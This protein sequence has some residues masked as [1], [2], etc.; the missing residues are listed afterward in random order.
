VAARKKTVGVGVAMVVVVRVAVGAVVGAM[1]R[2]AVTMAEVTMAGVTMA[3]VT[4]AGVTMAG[5]MKAAVVAIGVRERWMAVAVMLRREGQ[6]ERTLVV[7]EMG[8]EEVE[9]RLWVKET[10]LKVQG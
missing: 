2:I 7:M 1:L 5:V 3:G 8:L 6:E 4:M 9:R 10:K